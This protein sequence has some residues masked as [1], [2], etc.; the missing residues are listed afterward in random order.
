M[1]R[2]A[3]SARLFTTASVAVAWSAASRDALST[4]DMLPTSALTEL[5]SS[6]V[7]EAIAPTFSCTETALLARL[8]HSPTACSA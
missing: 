8:P 6:V 3:L 2:S 7:A 5:S 4:W 1:I